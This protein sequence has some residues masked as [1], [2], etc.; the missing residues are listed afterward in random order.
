[1]SEGRL[2]T[3]TLGLSR[4]REATPGSERGA[5]AQEFPPFVRLERTLTLGLEWT[6]RTRMVR[7][8]PQAGGF[9]VD[10]PLLPGEKVLTPGLRVREGRIEVPMPDG[11]NVVEW[12]SNLDKADALSIQAPGLG[13]RAEVWRVLVSPL[14]RA[15]FSGLPESV[16]PSE[17]DDDWHEFTFHPLPGEKL[18][19]AISKPAAVEGATQAILNVELQADVGQRA[20]EYTLSFRIRASQG[21]ERV[22]TL[23]AGAELLSVQRN[24]E[25]VSLRLDGG[26]LSLAV[27]PGDQQYVVRFRDAQKAGLRNTTPRVAFGLPAANIGLDLGLPGNRWVLFTHGPRVGPAVLYW[28]ELAVLLLVAW[29]LSRLRWTPLKLRDW[30]LLGIGFSTFSWIALAIVVAWLFAMGWRGR[31]DTD[32]IRNKAVFDLM[33]LGLAVLT[34]F[35]VLALLYAIPKG[36]LGQPDMHIVNPEHG[37][38]VLHWF[39]DQS[40]D[41]LPVAGTVSVPMWAYRAAML[42]WALWLA[43]AV[44]GW[45]KWAIRA[46]T[47]GGWWRPLRAPKPAPVVEPVEPV[48]PVEALEPPK[49]VE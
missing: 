34:F 13:E 10:V 15:S 9:S 28:G 32:G 19:I 20:S 43:M 39:A 41:A 26:K 14:W 33:Q 31:H 25:T 30:L 17:H 22:L 49:P 7:I 35:A 12:E 37:R 23:P 24:G 8:A 3:E 4:V 40:S 46:W 5:P 2:L 38:G 11:A 18:A 29:G 44:L 45:F 16:P 1:L 36:L 47:T 6:V 48:E 42:A 21:G 27:S